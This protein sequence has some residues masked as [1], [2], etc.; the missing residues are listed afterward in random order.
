MD[1]E[2]R[3]Q[4]EVEAV[5]WDRRVL[6]LPEGSIN[7]STHVEGFHSI[8]GG[9]AKP[10][11]LVAEDN[12][13]RVL[14]QLLLLQGSYAAPEIVSRP[15]L[16]PLHPLCLYFFN[17]YSW[18]EGP[19]VF[20]KTQ[21]AAVHSALLQ[22]VDVKARRRA[23]MVRRSTQPR[24]E[25]DTLRQCGHQLFCDYG[26]QTRKETTFH[27]HLDRPHEELWHGLK[28]SARKNLKKIAAAAQ[29]VVTEIECSED[30]QAYWEM[31]VETQERNGR[32]ISYQ[33]LDQF[34]AEFWDNPHRQGILKGLLCRTEDGHAIGGLLFRCFNGWIQELGVAYTDYSIEQRLYGHDI[35]KWHLIEWGS[36]NGYRIYDLMGVEIDS[37]DNKKKGIYQFKAK[38]GGDLAEFTVYDKVYS[39]WKAEM[40]AFGGQLR[41]RSRNWK[42]RQKVST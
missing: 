24:Y 15:M 39:L 22:Y 36:E 18:L 13:G 8:T 10:V 6:S 3:E 42:A 41:D 28:S 29:L 34:K 30:V 9:S 16:K 19:L 1:I 4:P 32:F 23:F 35:I 31:L 14:G 27:V 5:E 11:Y 2:V 25:D 37:A 33:T 26:F 21:F 38:W 7:Q 17:T 40:I 12:T 20:E